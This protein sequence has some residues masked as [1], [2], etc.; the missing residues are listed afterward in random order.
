MT[1]MLFFSVL[2][3]CPIYVQ[4]EKYE[5]LRS[6]GLIGTKHSITDTNASHLLYAA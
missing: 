1:S 4:P 5:C 3:G 2:T 6:R